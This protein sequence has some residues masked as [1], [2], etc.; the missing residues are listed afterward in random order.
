MCDSAILSQQSLF[1]VALIN[2]NSERLTNNFPDFRWHGLACFFKLCSRKIR[3]L[4]QAVITSSRKVHWN[5]IWL[6]SIDFNRILQI[7]RSMSCAL[8][9]SSARS[10]SFAFNRLRKWNTFLTTLRVIPL[11]PPLTVDKCQRARPKIKEPASVCECVCAASASVATG[12]M[13]LD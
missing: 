9:I 7:H 5:K 3:H 11:P 12:Q 10:V 2:I 6:L 4:C 1:F 8:K 13:K